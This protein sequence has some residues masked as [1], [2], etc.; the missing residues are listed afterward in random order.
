MPG[1]E[2]D[3]CAPSVCD[4]SDLILGFVNTRPTGDGQPELLDGRT[5][6]ADWLT[7]AGLA[8]AAPSATYAD[9]V[10]AQELR[11]AFVTI[12]RSHAGCV[13][14]E[15]AVP[16]AEAYL[17]RIAE[18]YPLTPRISAEGCTLVASQSGVPGAFGSL[19]AAVA[20]L[21]A[22]GGWSRVKV[23]KNSSCHSGFFDKTRNTSG[24][25][26]SAACGSQASMRAYRSR[27]RTG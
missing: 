10:A 20:D 2:A 6:L 22:R 4:S 23:C 8:D 18:R 13:D 25:Y 17:Q 14:D 19:F 27:L 3:A 1:T 9:A 7:R 24:L 21:A 15:T 11:A 12:L 5:G 26:C 16:D